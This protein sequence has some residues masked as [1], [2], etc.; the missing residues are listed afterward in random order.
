MTSTPISDIRASAPRA[1]H[2][3][4]EPSFY[5]EAFLASSPYLEQIRRA[6]IAEHGFREVNRVDQVPA[7]PLSPHDAFLLNLI[8]APVSPSSDTPSSPSTGGTIHLLQLHS[9]LT[10]LLPHG[11]STP[12]ASSSPL[13]LEAQCR[14]AFATLLT[15]GA[16]LI[17]D[18]SMAIPP[19]RDLVHFL[20]CLLPSH[21]ALAL[22]SPKTLSPASL[23]LRT[24]PSSVNAVLE[25][26]LAT[27][28]EEKE[29]AVMNGVERWRSGVGAGPDAKWLDANEDILRETVGCSYYRH[30]RESLGEN[31]AG[32]VVEVQEVTVR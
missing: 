22:S 5:Q 25:R 15:P 29:K 11:A 19:L 24:T 23:T 4:R 30:L 14:V 17:T 26:E 8:S 6:L 13:G 10:L 16:C 9:E 20:Q 18:E 31:G 2:L 27:K 12:P 3:R 28:T 21:S 32:T 1:Y 7:R